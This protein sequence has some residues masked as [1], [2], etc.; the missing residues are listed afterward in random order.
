MLPPSRTLGL[1]LVLLA[2]LPSLGACGD[3]AG[4]SAPGAAASDADRT[5][6]CDALCSLQTRCPDDEAEASEPCTC[7]DE[8]PVAELMLQSVVRGLTRCFDDLAC[9]ESDDQC[10]TDVLREV[11]PDLD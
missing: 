3:E 5:E 11:D 2:A 1:A 4:T 7:R 6:L 8:F 10:I 9:S